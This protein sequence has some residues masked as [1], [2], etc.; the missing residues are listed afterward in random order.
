M[1]D[2]TRTY[3]A[4][5]AT[6]HIYKFH[7]EDDMLT[8]NLAVASGTRKTT[9]QLENQTVSSDE[10]PFISING[11]LF[12]NNILNSNLIRPLCCTYVNGVAKNDIEDADYDDV[13]WDVY[14]SKSDNQLLLEA[15]NEKRCTESNTKFLRLGAYNLVRDAKKY[16]DSKNTELRDERGGK[17]MIGITSDL[18]DWKNDGKEIYIIVAVCDD[19]AG[20]TGDEATELMLSLGCK[21]AIGLDGGGSSCLRYRGENKVTSLRA[22]TDALIFTQKKT[23]SS[24]TGYVLNT[25]RLGMR[26]RTLPVTGDVI[27]TVPKGNKVEILEFIPGFQS[28]GY[29]WAKTR[30]GTITGY[31]QLDTNHCYSVT[32]A[33][34]KPLYLK[35]DDH[36]AYIRKAEVN[37]DVLVTVPKGSYLQIVE[38]L[39][40]F[41]DDGYQWART[42]YGNYEGYSQIDLKSWHTLGF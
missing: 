22:I 9:Y 2:L 40:G 25:N 41:G 17:T 6:V 31:S 36:G 24:S 10:E 35:T 4:A 27:K 29:Q 33:S 39:S 15:T 23:P 21:H 20:L 32:G 5:N 16:T 18:Y 13:N 8:A 11:G 3:G 38:L 34:V 42:K 28:D 14:F 7:I 19:T 26:I 12:V 30:Y 37:G 1:R